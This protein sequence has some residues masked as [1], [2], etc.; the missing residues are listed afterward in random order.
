M[1]NAL[2]WKIFLFV[3]LSLCIVAALVP[4]IAGNFTDLAM[5]TQSDPGRRIHITF[6]LTEKEKAAMNEYDHLFECTAKDRNGNSAIV[7]MASKP[8]DF[9]QANSYLAEAGYDYERH[10]IHVTNIISRDPSI[11]FPFIPGL[12]ERARI[13]FFHVPMSW[14][15]VIA[16]LVSMVYGIRYLKTKEMIFD[17]KSSISAGLGFLFCVLATVTGSI[18]AKFNWGSFWNW[19]PRETSIF[20]LMLVYGAYFALRSA[21][22]SDEKKASLSAVYSVLAFV[23]VPFFIFIMPRIMPGLH[24]GSADDSNSGPVVSSGGMNALMRIVL[25]STLIGFLILYAWLAQIQLRLRRTE[26]LRIP[27]S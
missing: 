16:F 8:Q 3:W 9:D 7:Y 27:N 26:N 20:V 25:Y 6:T 10:A 5:M 22:D 24:P 19:D 2:W 1:K 21:I 23:T 15:T 4:P 11:T 14:L 17:T 12:E 18:W 13:I